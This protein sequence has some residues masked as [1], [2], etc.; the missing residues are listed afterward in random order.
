MK[1]RAYKSNSQPLKHWRL[2]NFCEFDPYAIKSY[3]AIHEVDESLNFGDITLVDEKALDEFNMICGGSP[4]QDFSIAGEQKGSVWTCG[5]C[6]HSYN[7]LMVHWSMR[8]QC[9]VCG[10]NSIVKTRSSLLVEYLRVIR[11]NRPDFGLY[12]NVKNIVGKKFIDTTFKR[13]EEELQ[14]YGYN[15]YW[16]VL[17]AKDFGVPQNRERVYLVF[18]KKERDN[19]RFVF[20]EGFD[21]GIRLR[22]VLEDAV[23]EKYYLSQEIQD[24]FQ[25]T[26]ATF[27]KNIIGT[28]K[29]VYRTI[30]Q[31]DAVYQKD[32]IMGALVATDYKQPKQLMEDNNINMVGLLPIKGNEQIRRVYG[33]DGIAP[34]INTMQ[35]GNR[36]PKIIREIANANEMLNMII[37]S[38]DVPEGKSG[39]DC[40][41]NSP[42]L[43]DV[44]N[45]IPARYDCGV[46]R[47]KQFGTSVVERN[48]RNFYIRKLTPRECFRLMGF[49]DADFD[50]VKGIMSDTQLYKQA[51]NSIVTD[52][53]YYIFQSLYQVMP[54]LFED[55]RLS[56]FFSG[57]GAFE[58]ALDR[59]YEDMN[60]GE[61]N[62]EQ[63]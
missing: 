13:F 9:P 63:T 27:T 8:K 61:H 45:C 7:P 14:E 46:S 20:P 31:R 4:C 37:S 16:K 24:R 35:G 12:E 48:G 40:T 22:D 15:T 54:Y 11:A 55:L 21:N 39:A 2:V 32:G 49:S 51:G 1:K 44:A 34:T 41:I 43:R 38:A 29:P 52:V 10:S 56:S 42:Q 23:S 25:V 19:G 62:E 58:T 57:I 5:D 30:G 60:A 17:N 18:I 50:A 3:C 33:V 26:D 47:Y 53:L 36:Q 28:T 6:K 59:L